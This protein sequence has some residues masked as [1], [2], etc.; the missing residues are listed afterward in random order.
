MPNRLRGSTSP[1]LEQHADQPVAWQPWDDAALRE[2]RDDDKP[3]LL[4]IGYAA[5][6]W[7]H[8]MA[9]ESFDDAAIARKM[10]DWF[11]NI[12]VDREA[13]PDLDRTYQLAHQLLTGRGGGWPLT[14][15]LDPTDLVPFVAGTYFPPESRGGRIGFGEFLERVHAAW[16][17]QRDTLRE[18]NR[19]MT[20][21]LSLVEARSAHAA[22]TDA[23]DDP[24]DRLVGQLE[25]RE[26]ERHG[27][28][29]TAPKFP[30]APLLAWLAERADDDP[31][32]ER[33]LS[34]ALQAIVRNG[35]CDQIGGGFFRYCTDA[36]WEIPHYE[37]MLTD[38]AQL[39]AL[40]ADAA[41]R[42]GDAGLREAATRTADFLLRD[43]GLPGG[44]FATSLDA[45][46]PMPTEHR[47]PDSPLRPGQVPMAEG[48]FYRWYRSDVDSALEPD[49][50]ELA[51]ARFGFD[52]PSNRP[53]GGWHPVLAR[54]VDELV[55]PGRPA[56]AI[57]EG[58]DRVRG[59]LQRFRA[60]RPPPARDEQLRAGYN[61][62]TAAALARAGARMDRD[63]WIDAAA[64]T[65]DRIH[66][67]LLAHRPPRAVLRGD[68]A[69]HPLLLDD[70]AALLDAELALLHARFDP[71]RLERARDQAGAIERLHFD[72][73]ASRF[74]LTP[75][76]QPV[77][78]MRP[79]ADQDDA[80][81][82]GA[83][84]AVRG[85]ID[86]ARLTDEFEQLDRARS[87]ID[88][89][90]ADLGTQPS[91]HAT[92]LRALRTLDRP[93]PRVVLGGPLEITRDW[94]RRLRRRV[95]LDV[96]VVPAGQTGLPSLLQ[97]AADC[98]A[99]TA[100]ACTVD[101][102]L[103]PADRL[104]ALIEQLEALR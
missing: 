27:G 25:A 29:G 79:R 87:A 89:I 64:R 24:E 49:D 97:Q 7:C 78:V 80:Q 62:L 65:L 61:A 8:V 38:N 21:A 93:R 73:D 33:M 77:V 15:V 19:R 45:D 72:A 10:N 95:D 76:G 100:W 36:A 58:L 101:G 66:S 82:A 47:D 63:D 14:A 31:T 28:F 3:I 43:L 22:S 30:Q 91:A 34:D 96:L 55:G 98:T 46:S 59:R 92:W 12:K 57:R 41:A 2:A 52:G 53:D 1:Y 67:A 11:V 37:K 84:L 75:F 50:A 5:C 40:L 68:R 51:A 94:A 90:R 18:Q 56:E 86:L 99:A 17:A 81:P 16:L 42:W 9:H 26:D 104:E 102:C 6:H 39:L 20:E 44:G 74:S 48:A 13:R 32:A 103:A 60:R 88:A 69:E 23:H 4:S 70:R 35:L 83:A 54:S 85:W 71:D